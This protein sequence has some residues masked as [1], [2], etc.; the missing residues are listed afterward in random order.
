MFGIL[1]YIRG[2]FLYRKRSREEE[3]R[4]IAEGYKIE[5]LHPMHGGYLSYKE[6]EMEVW[7]ACAFIGLIDHRLYVNSFRSWSKPT[8]NE[9]TP[10]DYQKVKNRLIRFLE[11]DGGKVV[12]DEYKFETLEQTKER[13]RAMGIPFEEHD[14]VLHYKVDIKEHPEFLDEF[15]R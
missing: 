11:C 2:F 6:G 7:A 15:K 1:R 13:L 10:F 9:M 3:Q 5:R 14:G 4:Q 8:R 12:L